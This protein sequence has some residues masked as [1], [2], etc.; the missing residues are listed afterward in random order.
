MSDRVAALHDAVDAAMGRGYP[1]WVGG[2]S[3]PVRVVAAHADGWNRWGGEP[4]RFAEQAAQIRTLA[5]GRC[6]LSWGGLVVLG[7]DEGAARRKQERLDP[8]PGAIV[9][10]PEQVA[11]RW[12]AYIDA[13]AEWIVAGPVDS[14]DLENAAII[15]ERIVPLLA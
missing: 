2:T 8:P 11:E 12:R 10:G 15:G 7:E 9:G 14:A 3:A 4:S 5:A 13:G 1:V 6:T